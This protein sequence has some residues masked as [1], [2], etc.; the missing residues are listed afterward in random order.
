M[1]PSVYCLIMP[2]KHRFKPIP[3]AFIAAAVTSK[4]I[5]IVLQV[6][7]VIFKFSNKPNWSRDLLVKFQHNT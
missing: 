1:A 4:Q 6:L 3:N 2:H 7:R 5:F